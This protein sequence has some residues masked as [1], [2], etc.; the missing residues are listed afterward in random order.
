M[1]A[2]RIFR[3]STFCNVRQN[4][5]VLNTVFFKDRWQGITG[6][7]GKQPSKQLFSGGRY[8]QAS[9][10]PI[11]IPWYSSPYIKMPAE[12]A[13]AGIIQVIITILQENHPEP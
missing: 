9:E 6:K 10:P 12:K 7:G 13:P 2:S 4:R 3:V 1:R 8:L 5:E 11:L